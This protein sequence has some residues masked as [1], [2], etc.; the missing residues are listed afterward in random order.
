MRLAGE[1]YDAA[2]S[3]LIEIENDYLSLWG[4]YH[5]LVD[6]YERLQG[7]LTDPDLEWDSARGLG[8]A[9]TRTG[10]I[11][12]GLRCFEHGLALARGQEGKGREASSLLSIGWVCGEMGDPGKA[13]EFEQQALSMYE[14]LCD[15]SGEAIAR[16]NLANDL[17]DVGRSAEAIEQYVKAIA[18][19]KE[20][21]GRKGECTD[22][23]N[24]ADFYSDLGAKAEASSLAR[25]AQR[26]AGALGY[27]LIESAATSLLGNLLLRE[28]RFADAIKAHDEACAIADNSN[29]V[30]IQM[31]A[32]R[33][34]AWACLLAGDLPRA[35]TV[36]KDAAKYRFPK[37]YA[38]TLALGGVVAL[39]QGDTAAASNAFDRAL[40]EAEAQLA[41]TTRSYL[42][43]Y[44]KALA[45]AGL[46]LCRDSALATTVAKAYRDSR[47]ISAAPGIIMDELQKLDALAVADST[48][49][50]KPVRAAAAGEA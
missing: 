23:H 31:G 35:D 29:A 17:A 18:L 12:K 15:K 39:R 48:G 7:K 14:E 33:E 22:T 8:S 44:A 45:L 49:T 21:G 38:S 10:Q 26:L 6:R 4:H 47:A 27:R 1:D 19:D 41:G 34:L 20:V 50:L 9:Y 37:E 43:A 36:A 24:L 42:S 40:S 46:A 25:D 2:A 11:E 3:V 28:G 32:R 13:I 16:G 5:L 30:Q